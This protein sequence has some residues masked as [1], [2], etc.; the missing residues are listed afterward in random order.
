MDSANSCSLLLESEGRE[1]PLAKGGVGAH[2]HLRRKDALLETGWGLQSCLPS[3]LV[4]NPTSTIFPPLLCRGSKGAP[5]F[6]GVNL[7]TTGQDL[8]FEWS[9]EKEE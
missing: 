8:G 2:A 6:H 9:L 7:G 3:S 1:T 4:L 5:V